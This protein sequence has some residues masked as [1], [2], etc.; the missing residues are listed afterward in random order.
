VDEIWIDTTLV[1]FDGRV[2]EVFG[3]SG[4][5]S[6]R[7]H[8]RNIEIELQDPDRKGRRWLRIKPASPGSGGCMFEVGPEDWPHVGPFVDRVMAAIPEA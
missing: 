5:E 7:F 3:F 6:L 1:A 4:S 8:V 2:L